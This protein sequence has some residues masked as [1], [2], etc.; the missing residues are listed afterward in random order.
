MGAGCSAPPPPPPLSTPADLEKFQIGKHGEV[1]VVAPKEPSLAQ[2]LRRAVA[3]AV[4][5]VAAV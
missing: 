5:A 3:E 2:E 4:A 1:E